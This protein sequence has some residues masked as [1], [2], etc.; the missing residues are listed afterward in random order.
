[1]LK[2]I[3]QF[4][5]SFNFLVAICLIMS[6]LMAISDLSTAILYKP[7]I[8]RVS[9]DYLK[10]PLFDLGIG[11]AFMIV[12]FFPYMALVKLNQIVAEGFVFIMSFILLLCNIGLNKYYST[13]RV[14]L[15]SDLYGY[16]WEEIQDIVSKSGGF[17][18]QKNAIFILFLSIFGFL[19]YLFRFYIGK[20]RYLLLPLM[21]GGVFFLLS[22]FISTRSFTNLSFFITDSIQYSQQKTNKVKKTKK[23]LQPND[24][25][26]LFVENSLSENII[27]QNLN[28]KAEKPNIVIIVV[29]GMGR[30][31][32]GK[33]AQFP[34]F[35]PFLDSLSQKSLYWSN[36][37]SNAGRSFGALP[38]IMGSVP[39]GEKG[40]ME[41]EEIPDHFSLIT[42]LKQENYATNYYEGSDAFFDR[43]LNYLNAVGVENIVDDKTFE[44]NYVKTPPSKSGDSWGYPD[45]ELF[46]KCLTMM[47]P[48]EKPRLDIIFT[49]SNHEPFIIPNQ[50][51]YRKI[52]EKIVENGDF[53]GEE[54]DIIEEFKDVFSA[55]YYTDESIKNFIN[56][57]KKSPNYSNTVFVI[58]GDH[59]LI[60]VPM[61]DDICRYHV[62]L[63]ISSPLL[64][65]PKEFKGLSSHMD[66]TPSILSLLKNS[67]KANFSKKLPFIGKGLSSSVEFSGGK[68]EIPLMRYK[69]AFKDLIY[70]GNFLCDN[71][72]YKI[73]DNLAISENYDGD[74]SSQVNTQLEKFKEVNNYVTSQ[75]KIIPSNLSLNTG[76]E[77]ITSEEKKRVASLT[78]LEGNYENYMVA[79][80]L[81]FNGR[82]DDALFLCNYLLKRN[83]GS[84][85]TRTLKGRLLAWKGNYETAEKEFL[86]VLKQDPKYK[87]SYRALLSLYW[88]HGKKAKAQETFALA[89]KNTDANPEYM[90]ELRILLSKASK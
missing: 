21:L 31:F 82:K 4:K 83:P 1:M 66:I 74:V 38:S 33:G 2:K 24:T 48:I 75:N 26:P 76:I 58:T 44:K 90:S 17:D 89:Q 46:R 65:A 67:Y 22:S 8:D 57:Y 81:A 60:P 45:S 77:K 6:I 29:E 56:T 39:F 80:K 84:S 16:S 73:K 36:F 9:L 64:K 85:E 20:I 69:G 25:Y 86:F 28:L 5:N 10:I 88:W 37:V 55:V 61:K 59:R 62:P 68:K 12:V 3:A 87:D 15:G 18:L 7:K 23:Y 13:A 52:V 35:T 11:F 79:R 47:N 30:D 53:G 43:K 42:L 19:I 34:G 70:D 32:M 71:R 72:F 54:E 63:I 50:D 14:A 41:M 27:G 49:I 51:H 40:F 78:K